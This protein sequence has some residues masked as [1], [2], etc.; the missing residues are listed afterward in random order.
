M[1]EPTPGETGGDDEDED[2]SRRPLLLLIAAIVLLPTAIVAVLVF[3]TDRSGGPGSAGPRSAPPALAGRSEG[4]ERLLATL[5][6]ALGCAPVEQI[7][8]GRVNERVAAGTLDPTDVPAPVA[9][10]SCTGGGVV[11]DYILFS[12]PEDAAAL[13]TA[14]ATA[15]GAPI[16]SGTVT[17]CSHFLG[18]DAVVLRCDAEPDTVWTARRTGVPTAEV[19]AGL[20]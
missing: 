6:P 8:I 2:R 19:L 13:F 17:G 20:G 5:D 15:S 10:V 16:A 7:T 12:R 9:A 18:T 14:A 3:T 1:P 4:A 11:R